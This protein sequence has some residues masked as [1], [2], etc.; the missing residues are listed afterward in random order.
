M[1]E[2]CLAGF[3]RKSL[4]LSES[5][6]R[7]AKVGSIDLQHVHV[8]EVI[9]SKVWMNDRVADKKKRRVAKEAPLRR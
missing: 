1:K 9:L 7:F 4:L 3:R 6:W 2:G 5:D 8:R